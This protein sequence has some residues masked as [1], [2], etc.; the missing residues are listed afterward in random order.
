M[1]IIELVFLVLFLAVVIWG[2]DRLLALLPGNAALKQAVRIVAIVCVALWAL[3][4]AA[5]FFGVSMPWAP[6]PRT[7]TAEC[8]NRSRPARSSSIT[9]S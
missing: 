1:P 5:S 7:G 3:S 9:S 8:R 2:G 6:P 4:V